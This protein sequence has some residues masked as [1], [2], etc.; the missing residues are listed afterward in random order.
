[1]QANIKRASR[2]TEQC[3]DLLNLQLFEIAKHNH[4]SKVLRKLRNRSTDLLVMLSL[5]GWRIAARFNLR[6]R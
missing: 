6:R 3:A 5:L 4:L 1:M 2:Q